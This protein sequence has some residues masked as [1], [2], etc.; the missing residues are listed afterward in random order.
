[1]AFI[2]DTAGTAIYFIG[3]RT[4]D[5]IQ[6]RIVSLGGTDEDSMVPVDSGKCAPL[7]SRGLACEATVGTETIKVVALPEA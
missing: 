4:S 6:V 3:E 1:M 5:G 2:F 7:P